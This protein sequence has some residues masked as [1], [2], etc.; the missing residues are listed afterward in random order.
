MLKNRLAISCLALVVAL[1][2][3]PVL[4]ADKAQPAPPAPIP[5]QIVAAKKVFISNAGG[6][7]LGAVYE[8]TVFSRGPDRCYN[9]FYAAMK[10]WGRYE[11]VSTPGEADLIFEIRWSFVDT[12]LKLPDLGE[13][14]LVILDRATHVALWGFTEHVRGAALMGNRDKNFDLAMNSIVGDAKG[15]LGPG[16]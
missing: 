1:L 5:I 11:L 8:K 12:G 14:R 10:D 3:V 13:I 7:S 9:Q 2:P 15:L 4:A 16:Q 6:E